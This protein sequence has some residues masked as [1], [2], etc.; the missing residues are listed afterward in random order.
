M[1]KTSKP[2]PPEQRA[3]NVRILYEEPIII[4]QDAEH[5]EESPL[6]EENP[7]WPMVILIGGLIVALACG[8]WFAPATMDALW[9]NLIRR[10]FQ[11]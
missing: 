8:W 10:I 3:K 1:Q 5:L 9:T 11:G 2:P 6:P 7:S 4:P